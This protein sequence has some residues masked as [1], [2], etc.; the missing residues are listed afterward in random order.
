MWTP[1]SLSSR[2]CSPKYAG[3]GDAGF[4]KII[5]AGRGEGETRRRGVFRSSLSLDAGKGRRPST[6]SG[7]AGTRKGEERYGSKEVREY[8]GKANHTCLLR[9]SG[10]R[11]T[12]TRNPYMLV[13]ARHMSRPTQS[14]A[15]ESLHSGKGFPPHPNPLLL[16]QAQDGEPVE[17][18]QGRGRM[19]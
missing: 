3:H 2:A 15:P 12:R 16:R 19:P 9:H 14:R 13:I 10:P 18:H 17:P 7:Q 4:Q 5:F 6:S 8:R 1:P 11:E